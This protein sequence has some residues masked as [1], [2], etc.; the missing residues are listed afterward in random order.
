MPRVRWSL[1]ARREPL[2]DAMRAYL[3][4]GDFVALPPDLALYR[5]ARRVLDGHLEEL[6]ALWREHGPVI[7]ATHPGLTFAEY[8]L[9][10]AP[11]PRAGAEEEKH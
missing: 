3:V 8:Q 11:A 7:K 2:S 9:R 1:R 10:R 5:L 6:A 4:T